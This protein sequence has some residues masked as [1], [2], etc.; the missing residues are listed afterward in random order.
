[1]AP[2]N[3]E[4]STF[5]LTLRCWQ[6]HP[7]VLSDSIY[8]PV[9]VSNRTVFFISDGTGITA[10]TF[11]NAIL[12]QFE[13]KT[14]HIRLPFIDTVDKAHQAVRQINAGNVLMLRG[15]WNEPLLDEMRLFPYGLHDDQVDGAS[16]AFGLLLAPLCGIYI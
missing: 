3:G 14:R 10:E 9:I 5:S 13:T 6:R 7:G 11:G 4:I 1:M 2:V 15:S 12:A 8:P 16:R